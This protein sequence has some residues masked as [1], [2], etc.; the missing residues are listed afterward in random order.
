MSPSG[1]QINLSGK[2]NLGSPR[3]GTRQWRDVDFFERQ[4]NNNPPAVT[5]S[6]IMIIYDA[7]IYDGYF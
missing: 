3:I 7:V 6:R 2:F 4:R 1:P 5:N